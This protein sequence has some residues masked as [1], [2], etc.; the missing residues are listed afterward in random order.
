MNRTKEQKRYA[1]KYYHKN[2]E[3]IAENHKKWLEEHR[4]EQ[5][6]YHRLYYKNNPQAKAAHSH[7]NTLRK[8]I[9]GIR[10]GKRYCPQVL[11][12]K[13]RE[14]LL[15]RLGRD[16]LARYGN[17]HDQYCIDHIIPL[18]KFDLMKASERSK[19]FHISNIQLLTNSQNESKHQS[20][21]PEEKS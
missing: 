1:R 11:G 10:S 13:D 5:N 3:K 4:E 6:E 12:V 20:L 9:R 8:I 14:E 21:Y 18:C 2:K 7:R 16:K 19:A 17:A 15:D